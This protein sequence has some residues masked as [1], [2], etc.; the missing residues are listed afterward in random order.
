M[1]SNS[2]TASA[3][4]FDCSWP[5]P[6][7]LRFLHPVLAEDALAL[8]DQRH[9][10]LGGVRLGD[11]DQFDVARGAAGDGGGAGDAVADVLERSGWLIHGA[12][13]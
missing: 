6:L 2:A 5:T 13:L 3:A 7:R 12:L 1:Q 4:L 8:V 9:D 10:R 11:G